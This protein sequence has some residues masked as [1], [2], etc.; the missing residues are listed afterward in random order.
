MSFLHRGMTAAAEAHVLDAGGRHFGGIYNAATRSTAHVRVEPDRGPAF[1]SE[2]HTWGTI[3]AGCRTY[4]RW[5]PAHP[6]HCELDHQ[7][8]DAANG[9]GSDRAFFAIEA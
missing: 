2:C 6:E 7:R 9:R 4:V 8:L 5:N 1:E 3:F